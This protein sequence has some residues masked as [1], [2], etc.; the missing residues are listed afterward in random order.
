MQQAKRQHD[1]CATL[2]VLLLA[3]KMRAKRMGYFSREEFQTGA[4]A[5]SSRDTQIVG[6]PLQPSLCAA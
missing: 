4:P 2:Q 3:W 6:T 5:A 1:S